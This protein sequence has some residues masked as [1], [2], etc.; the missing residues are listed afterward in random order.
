MKNSILWL[1]TLILIA[2]CGKSGSNP[3]PAPPVP[4]PDPVKSVLTAPAQNSLCISGNVISATQASITLSWAAAANADSYEVG[5]KNLLTGV[6]TTQVASANQLT[7]TL[8][9]TTPYS[10]YVVSKSNSTTHTAVSD[11]WKFYVA[12]TGSITYSPFPAGITAPT[13]GQAFAAGVTTV[14]LTWTGSDV[15]NDIVGYDVYFGTAATPPLFKSNVTDLFLNGVTIA[16]GNTYYW[17]I[18]TKDSAGNTSDSGVF[19][20]VVK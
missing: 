13:F 17:K 20:F 19:Q 5:I 14:N 2:G 1:C 4:V 16:S 11:T 7:I 3:E 15:D 10:W 9:R 8:Q 18:I 6:V 12:G